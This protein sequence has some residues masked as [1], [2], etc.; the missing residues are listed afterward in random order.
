MQKNI[1]KNT[2]HDTLASVPV[3]QFGV[4]ISLEHKITVKESNP[5]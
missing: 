5:F 4:E 2:F 3:A 1:T